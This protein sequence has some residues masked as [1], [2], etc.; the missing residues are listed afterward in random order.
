MANRAHID[1]ATAGRDDLDR[2][3]RDLHRLVENQLDRPIAT[4]RPIT[5]PALGE[6]DSRTACAHAAGAAGSIADAT[7][8]SATSTTTQRRRQAATPTMPIPS[9]WRQ[10][11]HPEQPSSRETNADGR[12]GAHS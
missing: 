3:E 10:H 2:A 6:L 7:A 5:S 12:G 4:P 1:A 8:D 11:P 9:R